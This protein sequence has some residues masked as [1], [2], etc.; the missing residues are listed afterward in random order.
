MNMYMYIYIYVYRLIYIDIYVY[1]YIHT[2]IYIYICRYIYVY[3][4]IYI[5]NRYAQ[6]QFIAR[7]M[8]PTIHSES[9]NLYDCVIKPVSNYPQISWF[10][11]LEAFKCQTEAYSIQ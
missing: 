3:M 5:R 7:G 10:I 6:I 8:S 9:K 1:K 11:L 2:Y 4:Y